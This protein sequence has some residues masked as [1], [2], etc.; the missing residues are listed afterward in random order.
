MSDTPPRRRTSAE[1]KSLPLSLLAP[2]TTLASQR[3]AYLHLLYYPDAFKRHYLDILQAYREELS[4]RTGKRVGWQ[5]IRDMMMDPEDREVAAKSARL[6]TDNE[7]AK[8]RSTLVTLDNMKSWMDDGILPSDVKFQYVER[9]IRSLRIS[10]DVDEIESALDAAQGEYVRDAMR[11]FYRPSPNSVDMP[12]D[13]RALILSAARNLISGACFALPAKMI[14]SEPASDNVPV[15]LLLFR[16]YTD[17]VTPLDIVSFKGTSGDPNAIDF[18]PLYSGFLI[19]DGILPSGS[20]NSTAILGRLVI[21]KASGATAGDDGYAVLSAGGTFSLMASVTTLH[22]DLTLSVGEELTLLAGL[23]GEDPTQTG[24]S[25]GLQA[26]ALQRITRD[27]QI[28]ALERRL[29]FRYRAWR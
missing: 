27:A 11:L 3:P 26:A 15:C 18:V 14:A 5:T 8:L 19:C 17:H 22:L 13:L 1:G 12:D 23:F 29:V 4:R 7:K 16:E 25:V 20:E 2:S 6:G 24:N 9:F 21:V 10:G 28:E